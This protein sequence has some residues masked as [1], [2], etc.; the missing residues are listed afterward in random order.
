MKSFYLF[1]FGSQNFETN[2]SRIVEMPKHKETRLGR[3]DTGCLVAIFKREE[4]GSVF[5][6]ASLKG[7]VKIILL[8]VIALSF[9]HFCPK[10]E[11]T[12]HIHQ[13]QHS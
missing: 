9:P 6:L 10:L 1:F 11:Q 13:G 12:L 8:P 5:V 4:V 2:A 3:C 7:H